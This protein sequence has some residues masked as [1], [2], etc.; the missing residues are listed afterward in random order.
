VGD[1]ARDSA[2]AAPRRSCARGRR[3]GWR[4]PS[5]ARCRML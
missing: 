5:R 3:R 1:G 2:R 4:G